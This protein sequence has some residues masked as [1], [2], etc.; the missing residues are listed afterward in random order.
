MDWDEV[1]A[2]AEESRC[3]TVLAVA[4]AMAQRAGIAVP[5]GLFELQKEA[6]TALRSARSSR[7]PG[8]SWPGNTTASVSTT[9]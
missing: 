2:L 9:G 7:R 4:L 8:R 1:R 3:R 6:E 5:P